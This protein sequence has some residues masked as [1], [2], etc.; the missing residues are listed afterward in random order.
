ML[1]G[2]VMLAT[3][4]LLVTLEQPHIMNRKV[5]DLGEELAWSIYSISNLD[6]VVKC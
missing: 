4:H 3:N 2:L 1:A 6:R 5:Q